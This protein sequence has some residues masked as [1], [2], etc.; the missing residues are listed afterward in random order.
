MNKYAQGGFDIISEK[1]SGVSDLADFGFVYGVG[2]GRIMNPKCP[3]CPK[4]KSFDEIRWPA[5]VK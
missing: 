4:T 5:M 1:L 2:R 3:H